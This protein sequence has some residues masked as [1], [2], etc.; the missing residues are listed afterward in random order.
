MAIFG[1]RKEEEFESEDEFEEQPRKISRLRFKNRKTKNEPIKLW[2]KKERL[3]ILLV[4][5]ATLLISGFL[6]LSARNFKLAKLPR[7]S[8]INIDNLNP[9]KKQ[10][11]VVENMGS[12]VSIEKIENT[13]RLFREATNEYSGV[14]AFYIY[15]LEGNYSYGLNSK[16]VMQAASL[17]KLPVMYL[18]LK[19]DIDESLIEAMGKKSD[20][21]AFNKS[22]NMLGKEE[23]NKTIINLGMVNTSLEKNLTTPEE[24]GYFFKKLYKGELLDSNK[25]KKLIDY[26]TDTIFEKW[27]R[28]GIPDSIVLSHKYG[29]EVHVVNDAGIV[30]FNKPFVVVIMTDGVIEKE[31][32]ELFPKLARLLYTEHTE[33]SE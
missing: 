22:V 1:K 11:I 10:I 8:L 17:I 12:S 6:A 7:L 15:D 27:L 16:E 25:S 33:N 26:M 13:K 24:V 9:F 19:N 32:D 29:R 31:A 4:L 3:S 20:N 2:G 23:I 5:M 21:F 28:L 30:F 14:Y 18:A